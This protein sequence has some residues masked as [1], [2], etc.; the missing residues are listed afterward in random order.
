MIAPWALPKAPYNPCL[1]FVP[2]NSL[3]A[4]ERQS[5]AHGDGRRKALSLTGSGAVLCDVLPTVTV[6]HAL[7]CAQFDAKSTCDLLNRNR[8]FE[9]SHLS[10]NR[11]GEQ[12]VCVS[13]SSCLALL[14]HHILDVL[15]VSARENMGGVAAWWKV[16]SMTGEDVVRQDHIIGEFVSDSVSG[17]CF[18]AKLDSTISAV[19]DCPKERPAS[20]WSRILINQRPK[21]FGQVSGAKQI[22]ASGGADLTATALDCIRLGMERGV[23][24]FAGSVQK[25]RLISHF[26]GLLTGYLRCLMPGASPNAARLCAAIIIPNS[27]A[28]SL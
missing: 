12:S 6:E 13:L 19:N 16:A 21:A 22:V 25:G 5:P 7:S 9:Q 11:V 1:L 18:S 10:N 2:G 17:K 20:I 28:V 24:P 3:T 14:V 26:G 27:L 4:F 8:P 23:T 15:K